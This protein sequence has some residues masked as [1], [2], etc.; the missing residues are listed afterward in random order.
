[1]ELGGV[2]PDTAAQLVLAAATAAASATATAALSQQQQA[3]AQA[4]LPSFLHALPHP[5]CCEKA[6]MHSQ[7]LPQAPYSFLESLPSLPTAHNSW[8]GDL[9]FSCGGCGNNADDL[10]AQMIQ[11]LLL[12]N[13]QAFAMV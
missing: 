9:G 11:A 2:P 1:M 5:P 12:S 10:D 6:G 4:A 3:Q 7:G 8:L 13:P